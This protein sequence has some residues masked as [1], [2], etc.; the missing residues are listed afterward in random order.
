M[1]NKPLVKDP[2]NIRLG[3]IGMTAGNGHPFSWSAIIN[4]YDRTAMEKEC[5]FPGITAYMGKED[6]ARIGV[7]GVK[8]THVYCNDYEDACKVARVSCIGKVVR[9]PD[10][11]IGEV[12]AVII[13]TDI[14]GEHV[15]RARPFVEAGLPV[16]IDK[17]LCDNRQDLATFT[18]WISGGARIM[19][20]SSMRYCKEYQ[21]YHRNTGE[22]GKMCH[23]YVPMAK[24]WEAYGIHA[25]EAVYPILGPGF[26]SI[27]NN[28]DKE[29]NVV[30]IKHKSG[31]FVTIAC[32]KEMAYGG[33]M[34]LGGSAGSKILSST[35]T[36]YAFRSQLM[37][38]IGYLRTGILPFEFT[39][40]QELM[41]LVIGGIESR[42]QGNIEVEI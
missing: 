8:V 27:R 4:N 23:I 15:D 9:S 38:F 40:T 11:M 29:H 30:T 7:P 41:R 12:D 28:G 33:A 37:A 39:E 1:Q 2:G 17:P 10:E 20:S 26:V 13:A 35:D 19:S 3:I 22:L 34:V 21:P 14:G 6:H 42:E 18:E 24:S 31:C 5:P 36:Y 25:L 16:F 32:I